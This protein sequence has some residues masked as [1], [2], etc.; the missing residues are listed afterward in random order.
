MWSEKVYRRFGAGPVFKIEHLLSIWRY[1]LRKAA[2]KFLAFPIC[3]ITKRTFL[4][5]VKEVR[6][7]KS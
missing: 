2:D 7:T 6:T 3:S 1:D 4:G 5:W